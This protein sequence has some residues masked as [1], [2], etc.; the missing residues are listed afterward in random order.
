MKLYKDPEE[1]EQE[2]TDDDYPAFDFDDPI[3]KGDQDIID[4]R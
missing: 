4:I 1:E 3:V 2:T